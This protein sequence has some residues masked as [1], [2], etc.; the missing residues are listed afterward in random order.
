MNCVRAPVRR[1]EQ[2]VG[3]V[4]RTKTDTATRRIGGAPTAR[5]L[6]TALAGAVLV[7]ATLIAVSA[8]PA[9]AANLKYAAIV[10]DAGGNGYW[11]VQSGGTAVPHGS[12]PTLSNT[13]CDPLFTAPVLGAVAT[14]DHLGFWE[15]NAKGGIACFGDAVNWGSGDTHTLAHPIVGMSTSYDG[16]G[17]HMVDGTGGVIAWGDACY[18]GSPTTVP[19][20]KPIVAV[21]DYPFGSPSCAST[22]Y[23]EVGSSGTVYAF[24]ASVSYGTPAS[25]SRIVTI[26]S[27][28][29]GLGYWELARSGVV[30]NLGSAPSLG[31]TSVAASQRMVSMA[32]TPAGDGYWELGLHGIVWPHGTAISYGNGP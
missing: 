18:L 21:T 24:G 28:P 4:H 26:V 23:T 32:I 10:G 8:A 22:G 27:T 6:I 15:Y 20:N 30:T 19:K 9:G 12:A 13:N 3:L 1:G 7:A 2:V 25:T 16:N 17:Y 29:D 14:P 11:L 31:W 5:R